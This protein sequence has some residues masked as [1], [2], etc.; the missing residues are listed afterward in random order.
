[1]TLRLDYACALSRVLVQEFHDLTDKLV[2]LPCM[3]PSPVNARCDTKVLTRRTNRHQQQ[4]STQA[5]YQPYTH[6]NP[7][8]CS[9]QASRQLC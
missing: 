2:K 4:Q 8:A 6:N 1:M 3:L 9:T 7:M 5:A